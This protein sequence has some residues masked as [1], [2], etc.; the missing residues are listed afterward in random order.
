MRA[1]RPIALF[2]LL[3]LAGCSGEPSNGD[4]H[5]ALK[6]DED[7]RMALQMMVEAEAMFAG[8]R[9]K[10]GAA[11]ARRMIEEMRFEKGSCV[12]AQ[13]APGYVCDF[14]ARM[15]GKKPSPPTKGR[16]FKSGGKWSFEEVR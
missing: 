8:N 12:D 1:S 6:D 7:F 11:D 16:F 14:R 15:P 13:N 10:N 3:L 2:S 5:E 9:S 4:I